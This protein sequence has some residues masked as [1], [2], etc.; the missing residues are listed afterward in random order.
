MEPG[1]SARVLAFGKPVIGC[2]EFYS[3]TFSRTALILGTGYDDGE[4][5][6]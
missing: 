6:L 2:Y 4:I 1:L 3:K 5:Q